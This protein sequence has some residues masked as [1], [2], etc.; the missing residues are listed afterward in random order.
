MLPRATQFR[1]AFSV[2]QTPKSGARAPLNDNIPTALASLVGD[3][4][5]ERPRE[6]SHWDLAFL[7]RSHGFESVDPAS[8]QNAIGKIKRVTTVLYWA[9]E[10]DKEAG[11]RLV[12][13]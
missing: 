1:G 7:F 3:A 12:A 9:I 10:Q 5:A 13:P 11:E 8:Q 4:Q 2:S 6:P